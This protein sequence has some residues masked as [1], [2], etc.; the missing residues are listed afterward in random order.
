[1]KTC[2]L[3]AAVVAIALAALLGTVP[4]SFAAQTATTKTQAPE[5]TMKD[6]KRQMG[7]TLQTIENYSAEQR[8]EAV[9]KAQELLNDLDR[10]I[11]RMQAQLEKGWTKMSESAR[12]KKAATLRALRKQR[13][14]VAEWYGGL[15]YSSAAAWEDVKGGF[16]K[17]YD[18]L[19]D[20]LDKAKNQF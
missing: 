5:T 17:S 13:N 11:D 18:A 6:V 10:R 14:E 9:K 1:M 8:D 16:V 4:A 2:K 15:K 19:K 20:A 3:T 7:N 12:E